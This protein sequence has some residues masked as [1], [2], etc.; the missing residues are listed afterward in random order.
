MGAVDEATGTVPAAV[1]RHHEDAHGSMLVLREIIDHHSVP[2][3]LY[4]DKHGIFQRSPKEPKSLQYQ[5]RGRR[6]PTQFARPLEELDIQ[7]IV[8]HTPQT[9]GRIERVLG[10]FQDRLVSELPGSRPKPMTV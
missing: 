8:A 2:L 7:R 1:F 4:S 9:K 10:T 5:L 6:D 3:A